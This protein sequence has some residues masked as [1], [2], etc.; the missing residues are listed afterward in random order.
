MSVDV[1]KSFGIP[2][3]FFLRNLSVA[4]QAEYSPNQS[5]LANFRRAGIGAKV[6]YPFLVRNFSDFRRAAQR[7]DAVVANSKFVADR[8]AR[9]FGVEAEVLYP[10]I[11][12][13]EF[14][15]D[16]D[17]DGAIGMVNPRNWKNRGDVFL[18]VAERL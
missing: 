5:H 11:R 13:E 18:D 14:E 7:A 17:L 16:Y 12:L 15:V 2:S 10:L 4:G 6:Q 8:I 9:D 3:L 1:A